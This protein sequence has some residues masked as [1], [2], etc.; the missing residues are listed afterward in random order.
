MRQLNKGLLNDITEYIMK[1]QAEHGCSPGQRDIAAKFNI[2]SKRTHT[3]VHALESRGIIKLDDSGR[4]AV[5][6]N[7]DSSDANN[8]PLVGAVKCGEPSLAIE[9][10]D[11]MFRLPREFTG[12]GDFFM[13]RAKG[14]SM[15]GANIFEGDYLVIREQPAVESGDI[16]LAVRERGYGTA[17]AEATL[18]RYIWKNGGYVLHPEN[19]NYND[20]DA[21]K[22][23]IVGKLVSF[24][25][26]V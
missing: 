1:R 9:E 25:R 6:R 19:E 13:I 7:L 23:H 4:I 12:T 14:D 17:D 22:F 5:P 21:D 15:T 8:V 18:K 11:G 16:V 20:I 24:I 3:Y 26:K 10:F 2:N